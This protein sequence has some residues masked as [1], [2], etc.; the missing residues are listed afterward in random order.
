M[1]QPPTKNHLNNFNLK[2]VE[3]IE[4]F[5]SPQ[6]SYLAGLGEPKKSLIIVQ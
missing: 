4:G 2:N 3:S 5:I 1:N 6:N